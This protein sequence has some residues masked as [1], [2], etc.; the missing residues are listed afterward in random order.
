MKLSYSLFVVCCI[1]VCCLAY[2]STL[3]M[4]ATTPSETSVYFQMTK[5]KLHGSSP[6]ANYTDRATVGRRRS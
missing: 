3:R 2:S 5:T 4:E 6:E 1:L